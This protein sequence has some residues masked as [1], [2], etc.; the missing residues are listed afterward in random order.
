MCNQKNILSFVGNTVCFCVFSLCS[1]NVQAN[2]F[3]NQQ[4]KILT[5]ER[6]VLPVSVSGFYN[7]THN[8]QKNGFDL[9]VRG[10]VG[11]AQYQISNTFLMN[12][13]Y[14]YSDAT[15]KMRQQKTNIQTDSYFIYGKYQP[16]KWYLSGQASY[17]YVRYKDDNAD[18]FQKG[19]S[20]IYQASFISGYYLGNVHNYSGLKYTYV[21]AKDDKSMVAPGKNGEVVTAFIGTQYAPTYQIKN[22]VVLTPQFQFA[23]SYDLKSNNH[24]AV[25]DMPDTNVVFALKGSRLHRAAL[26]TGVG[27]DFQLQKAIISAGYNV[28][29]RVSHF[30]QTG[31]IVLK[32]NF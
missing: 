2:E 32:Y 15:S 14:I 9:N 8:S 17:H 23:G 22:G 19:K 16:E 10:V 24:H 11:Q 28:D 29:W 26:K 30:S 7:K 27:I 1:V 21:D 12:V 20:D 6:E 4:N 13:G 18:F 25:V 31:K 5:S 3:V